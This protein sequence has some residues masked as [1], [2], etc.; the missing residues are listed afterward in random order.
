MSDDLFPDYDSA[1]IAK[2]VAEKNGETFDTV[3][4]VN[5]FIKKVN[6]SED[7]E[8]FQKEL[9]EEYAKTSL[10]FS[11]YLNDN[12]ENVVIDDEHLEAYVAGLFAFGESDDKAITEVKV[13]NA[14][15][16]QAAIDKANFDLDLVAAEKLV[17]A[18]TDTEGKLV[19]KPEIAKAKAAVNALVDPELEEDAVNENIEGLKERVA[20][21][22]KTLAARTAVEALFEEDEEDN[23]I[24]V[25]TQT[26]IDNAQDLVDELA[27]ENADKEDLQKGID[28]AQNHLNAN[29]VIDM[30]K[31]LPEAEEITEDN[32]DQ[33]KPQVVAA[34]EA[35]DALEDVEKTLVG[36]ELAQATTVENSEAKLNVVEEKIAELEAPLT[37]ALEKVNEANDANALKKVIE[38]GKYPADNGEGGDK[39]AYS[40]I[41]GLNIGEGGDYA[42][43]KTYFGDRQRAVSVD[44]LKNKPADGYTLEGLQKMFN[45]IVATRLVTQESMDLV[46]NAEK[47]EDISYITML[48]DRFKAVDYEYHSDIK[49]SERITNLEGY[50][51]D[52]NYLNEDY[53]EK[54]LA[55][56][57]EDRPDGGYSRSSKT[58]SA[59]S[60]QLADAVLNSAI[61]ERDNA[62]LQALIIEKEVIEFTSLT[63]AQRAEVVQL[64][65]DE[66]L[67]ADEYEDK[68]AIEL[69][70]LV[71]VA[72]GSDDTG[73]LGKIK[74]FKEAANANYPG[75]AAEK[76]ALIDAIKDVMELELTSAQE[77][78]LAEAIFEAKPEDGYVV[79]TIADIVAIVNANL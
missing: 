23:E 66:A 1:L 7:V 38:E 69:E 24:L 34:R 78:D 28:E 44:L 22:E 37:E 76:T 18:L 6:G 64:I 32:K 11:N 52:F 50:I 43:L 68:D 46:N 33:V 75:T 5:D 73:Y 13:G 65:I 12:Y 77:L 61:V 49:I 19:E 55:K 29:L 72:V 67:E 74:A 31:A 26:D 25:G 40:E 56:V 10:S 3:K 62:K 63:K 8:D 4:D 51:E 57:I 39:V 9:K 36:S 2:Y 45:D 21:A 20:E 71:T 15:D 16:V 27:E 35:F 53:Q 30:I 41:L 14:E 60:D 48:V 58:I 79:R 54:V 70:N 47:L 17:D 42:K 59:L